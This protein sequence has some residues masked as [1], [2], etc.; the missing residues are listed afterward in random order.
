[1][2]VIDYGYWG[3]EVNTSPAVSSTA[4]PSRLRSS[5]RSVEPFS[6]SIARAPASPIRNLESGPGIPFLDTM[7]RLRYRLRS[8]VESFRV[9]RTCAPASPIN[10]PPRSRPSLSRLWRSSVLTGPAYLNVSADC[11]LGQVQIRGEKSRWDRTGPVHWYHQPD[12][13]QVSESERGV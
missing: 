10:V 4:L 3:T 2:A 12:Y 6:V 1:M 7:D 9:D 11:H 13:L 5:R 8:V